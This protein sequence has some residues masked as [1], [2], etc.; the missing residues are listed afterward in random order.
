[1]TPRSTTGGPGLA[2]GAAASIENGTSKLG[3]PASS[4]FP[5][6]VARAELAIDRRRTAGEVG[7]ARFFLALVGRDESD[8]GALDRSS[9]LVHR[10]S[11]LQQP[12]NDPPDERFA[13]ALARAVRRNVRYR[14]DD[15]DRAPRPA[16]DPNLGPSKTLTSATGSASRPE[17]LDD[18]GA[19][20][21]SEHVS[22]ARWSCPGDRRPDS[23]E[24]RDA[25]PIRTVSSDGRIS[26]R[27]PRRGANTPSRTWA[28]RYSRSRAR[29][30]ATYST[31][32]VSS[33][34][35]A[36]SSS[37]AT[38]RGRRLK[39]AAGRAR[40]WTARGWPAS[41]RRCRVPD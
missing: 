9:G 2:P 11:A 20:A 4:K 35:R 27:L 23:P 30:I 15:C 22:S 17:R 24:S 26:P 21:G 31:R 41:S 38:G 37:S 10:P 14:F 6:I 39:R 36:R 29:V 12:M 7:M 3:W 1:M 18:G 28:A 16:R 19:P 33:R 34:S 8:R 13:R 25:S 40:P 5:D 32:F